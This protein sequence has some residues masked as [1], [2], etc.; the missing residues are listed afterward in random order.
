MA[1]ECFFKTK[2]MGVT[3]PQRYTLLCWPAWTKIQHTAADFKCT[4]SC[5]RPKI[6]S[7]SYIRDNFHKDQKLPVF[8]MCY[9]FYRRNMHLQS[10][11]PHIH[12]NTFNQGVTV[13]LFHLFFSLT[14]TK[15]KLSEEPVYISFIFLQV[16]PQCR[17]T[18]LT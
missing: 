4:N 1:G 18:L 7:D 13:Q 12:S 3:S 14:T 16:L 10:S 6:K 15:A 11:H 9:M 2:W 5:M 8:G 17:P